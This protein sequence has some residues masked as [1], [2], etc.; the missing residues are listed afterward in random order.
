MGDGTESFLYVPKY[1][2]P[3]KDLSYKDLL[4]STF[5]QVSHERSIKTW[6]VQATYPEC[7]CHMDPNIGKATGK[8]R[9]VD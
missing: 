3:V 5:T 8:E 6:C 1:N 4:T 2:T 9:T 7:E